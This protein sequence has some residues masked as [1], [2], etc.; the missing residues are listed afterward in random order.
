MYNTYSGEVDGELNFDGGKLPRRGCP[1]AKRRR[2]VGEG[3]KEWRR[4]RAERF[5]AEESRENEEGVK[6]FG[7]DRG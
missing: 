5:E 1:A 7:R 4:A 3:V 2:L 6:N